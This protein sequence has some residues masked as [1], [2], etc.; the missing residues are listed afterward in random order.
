MAFG[1]GPGGNIFRRIYICKAAKL[2]MKMFIFLEVVINYVA[3]I[4]LCINMLN[5]DIR[6][7]FHV[8][9]NQI[10]ADPD[11]LVS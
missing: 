8:Q 7:G 5:S 9:F 10:K 2:G 6:Y 11:P 4:K 3:V 1:V